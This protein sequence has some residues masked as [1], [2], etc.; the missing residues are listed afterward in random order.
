MAVYLLSKTNITEYEKYN[1]FSFKTRF[2][3]KIITIFRNKKGEN[4]VKKEKLKNLYTVGATLILLLSIGCSSNESSAK[5][6]KKA[7]QLK[8]YSTELVREM[9]IKKEIVNL[10]V[11]SWDASKSTG[12]QRCFPTKKSVCRKFIELQKEKERLSS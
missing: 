3:P 8:P 1:N 7:E 4:K 6:H 2:I 9:F 10:D 11:A 5:P 12:F